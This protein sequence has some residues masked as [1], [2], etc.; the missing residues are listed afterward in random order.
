MSNT[1]F[2]LSEIQ[3]VEEYYRGVRLDSEQNQKID[4]IAQFLSQYIS[5]SVRALKGFIL[6][7]LRNIQIKYQVDFVQE[8]KNTSI[9]LA[10]KVDAMKEILEMLKEEL[11]KVLISKEQEPALEQAFKKVIDFYTRQIG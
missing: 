6:R 4:S 11:T 9:S 8:R 2:R 1:I 5:I 7:V 10:E 3:Q